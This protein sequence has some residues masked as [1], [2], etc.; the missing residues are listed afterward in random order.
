M[1]R[2]PIP[3]DVKVMLMN[4]NF[5]LRCCI[6]GEPTEEWHHALVFGGRS[7]QRWWAILP[8]TRE[9]HAIADRKDIRK[10]MVSIMRERGGEEVAFYEKVRKL[11]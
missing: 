10:K 8:V 7:V 9:I 2:T 5:M 3:K 1:R 4:D 6:S 11:T